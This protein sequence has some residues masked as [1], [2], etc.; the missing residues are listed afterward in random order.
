V[1]GNIKKNIGTAQSRF[2]DAKKEVEDASKE[3]ERERERA[4]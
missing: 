4:K 2:G 3:R 1:K